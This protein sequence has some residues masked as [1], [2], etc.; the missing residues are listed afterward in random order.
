MTVETHLMGYVT[1]PLTVGDIIGQ[2]FRICRRQ[3]PLIFNVL[4]LP[5]VLLGIGRVGVVLAGSYAFQAGKEATPQIA[6]AVVGIVGIIC[7]IWGGLLLAIRQLALVR[8][9]TGF[10]ATIEAAKDFVL[11][12]GWSIINLILAWFAICLVA[13]ISWAVVAVLAAPLLKNSGGS[14][15]LASVGIAVSVLGIFI[16]V[17][18][19]G[20]AGSLAFYGLAIEDGDL[21]AVLAKAFNLTFRSFLRT[22][23][24]GFL[25]MLSI[26]MLAYP[27]TL[28]IWILTVG[29]FLVT[30]VATG[31]S[32][33]TQL[34]AFIQVLNALWETVTNMVI[35]PICYVAYGL[36]FC[37]LKMRLEGS[38]LL[39]RLEGL[40]SKESGDGPPQN[41]H[42]V[43]N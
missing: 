30:G 41:I 37:D 38:D 28:P 3:V 26:A 22:T 25:S 23:G 17:V 19:L 20:L 1:K 43:V 33:T 4:L 8:L 10:A 13:V 39:S 14:A 5:T 35:G 36:F 11:K 24:F 42:A 34:P 7:L 15:V 12:R 32:E 18:Y 6:W 27:L 21:G 29:Y 16:T 40:Q 9:F 2:S 31:A